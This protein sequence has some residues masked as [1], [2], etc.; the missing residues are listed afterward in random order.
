M[1]SLCNLPLEII[2]IIFNELDFKSQIIFKQQCKSFYDGLRIYD[3]HNIDYKYL[4]NITDEILLNFKYARYLN[5]TKDI[6]NY[7]YN[8]INTL[9]SKITSTGIKH[10]N[11]HTLSAWGNEKITDEAIINMHLHTLDCSFNNKI[12]DKGIKHMNLHI[13]YAAGNNKITDEGIKYMNLYEL[14]AS[15]RCNITD[16]GIKHMD[17]HS[18]YANYNENINIDE[19]KQIKSLKLLQIGNKLFFSTN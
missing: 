3:L 6:Y 8:Q 15:R 13:L 10:L 14:D 1:N 12:T 2:Q 18:L 7:N 17:L 9:S 4:N 19:V 11:L 16:R 5:A